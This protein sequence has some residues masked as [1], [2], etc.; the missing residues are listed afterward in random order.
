MMNSSRSRTGTQF[1]PVFRLYIRK[2]YLVYTRP[3]DRRTEA[4]IISSSSPAEGG[5]AP[6]AAAPITNKTSSSMMHLPSYKG[7]SNE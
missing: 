2:H 4:I 5:A 7:T 3:G 1:Y 6:E